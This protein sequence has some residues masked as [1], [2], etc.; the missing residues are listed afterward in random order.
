MVFMLGLYNTL[1]WANVGPVKAYTCFML[2]QHGFIRQFY[3]ANDGPIYVYSV[4]MFFL[5]GL[6]KTLP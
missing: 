6:Y 5:L 1:S 3:C 4:N 2:G